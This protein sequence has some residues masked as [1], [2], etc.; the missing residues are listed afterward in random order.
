MSARQTGVVIHSRMSAEVCMSV[1]VRSV[2]VCMS[3][4]VGSVSASVS[5]EA[6]VVRVVKDKSF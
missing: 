4:S 6:R 1:S 3:V 5:A 2:S